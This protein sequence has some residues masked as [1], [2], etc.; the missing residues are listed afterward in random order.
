MA[1]GLDDVAA[2]RE[3]MALLVPAGP[4]P[5]EERLDIADAETAGVGVRVYR[6]RTPGP[7]PGVLYLHGGGFCL[8]SVAMEHGGAVQIAN[9]IDAVVVSVE[10]RL[11][12]EFPYPAGLE[13]CYAGLQYLA[14]LEGVD[15]SRLAVHGQ[16]AG[17]GLA[18][19]TVLLAHDR[20][21]P[22]ARFQSLGIPELDDRLETPSMQ[23]FVGTPLWS[24]PQAVRSWQYYLGG[25]P[26]DHYAAPARRADLS[27]LPPAHITTMELDPLRDEGITYA[28]RL[29]AAGVSVELHSYPGTFHGSSL[30]TEAAVSKRMAED[31]LGALR[32]ALNT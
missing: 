19:A 1:Q 5:G 29:L 27:G 18:A 30:V 9:A 4:V 15:S 24:R 25:K 20:G 3:M 21:G 32:R 23:A 13:D 2:A 12:P 14:A 28:M 16:S 31:M 22:T 6:P 7:H 11:A 8:G 10:Y 26:A 17:G